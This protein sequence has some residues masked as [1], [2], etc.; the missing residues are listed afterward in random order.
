[1]NEAI[2][3]MRGE[4]QNAKNEAESAAAARDAVIRR[5]LAE[6]ESMMS[7][8]QNA[9]SDFQIAKANAEMFQIRCSDAEH[10]ISTLR[11]DGSDSRR[12]VLALEAQLV[13][14]K[15]DKGIMEAR[16]NALKESLQQQ[17]N[18]ALDELAAL[19]AHSG[20]FQAELEEK[21]DAIKSLEAALEA[22]RGNSK[23]YHER[24]RQADIAMVA[25]RKKSA[26]AEKKAATYCA[27]VHELAAEVREREERLD[28][29]KSRLE[30]TVSAMKT[31]KCEMKRERGKSKVNQ[32]RI[33]EI[34]AMSSAAISERDIELSVHQKSAE[35]A[36]SEAAR[37]AKQHGATMGH[38][39]HKQKI[40]LLANLKQE[41]VKL[42][43]QIVKLQ[44]ERA[45][46]KVASEKTTKTDSSKWRPSF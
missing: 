17:L 15:E 34:I 12:T 8:L 19:K 40:R 6:K 41:N 43:A 3:T 42:R 16:M 24:E 28:D 14:L 31:F 30:L 44:A 39:N 25:E 18:S 10:A 45:A 38:T 7:E 36:L 46:K 32:S 13:P 20:R 4:L 33:D 23:E 29:L 2:K 5:A 22:Y 1:M 21:S 9:M 26:S 37:L 27:K 35:F 11:K